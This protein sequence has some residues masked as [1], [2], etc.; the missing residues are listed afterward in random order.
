MSL[1]RIVASD[2]SSLLIKNAFCASVFPQRNTHIVERLRP[3]PVSRVKA[4]RK[5]ILKGRH[6]LYRTV[7]D[8]D[9]TEPPDLKIVLTTFVDGVG[10]TGDV[11]SLMPHFAREH[12]LL[13]Q[14][15]VYATPENI[16]RLSAL[17][18]MR[19]ERPKFSSIHAGM[20][21]KLLS[22]V[23]IPV[24]MNPKVPWS[25]EKIHIHYAF[26]NEDFLV[27]EDCIELPSV[28]IDGPDPE[29][30]EKDFAVHITINNREKFPVRCRLFHVKLGYEAAKLSEESYLD[31]NESILEE[32]KELLEQMPTPEIVNDPSANISL[33]EKYRIQYLK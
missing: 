3:P 23:V 28:P 12:F 17:K 11:I 21:M 8:T 5:R 16:D 32:Q 18:K 31:K 13:P 15:A 9:L 30:E 1:C 25:I 19:P 22:K 33:V 29:K 24:F 14:K 7:E 4:V 27:P 2:F 10:D 6:F 26:R 20:T